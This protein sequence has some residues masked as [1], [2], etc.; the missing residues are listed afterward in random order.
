MGQQQRGPIDGYDPSIYTGG[1]PNLVVMDRRPN[2]GDFQGYFLGHWWIIPE[3]ADGAR[4]TEEVWVLVSKRNNIAKWKRLHGGSGPTP[5]TQTRVINNVVIAGTGAGTYIPS[6]GVIQVVVEV[7]GSGG[8]SDINGN[9][10]GGGGYAKKGYTI[11]EIGISQPYFIGTGGSAGTL[12]AFGSPPKVNPT[13]GTGTTFS[14]GALLI[15]G[16]GGQA[17]TGGT[18]SNSPGGVGSGGDLNLTG[19]EGSGSY[20][21]GN[22]ETSFN[23]IW[24]GGTV[25]APPA[26]AQGGYIDSSTGNIGGTPG[27]FP[28]GGAASG[29]GA[30]GSASWA[31]AAGANGAIFITEYFG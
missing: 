10:G 19:G 25:Y 4:P 11:E 8:G 3:S 30:N 1:L 27:I 20:P 9:S 29:R 21:A 22:V 16:G 14:A 24:S 15:T 5:P 2:A 18:T 31:G 26:Y 23:G 17:N 7:I 28:G 6:D 12:G 13:S